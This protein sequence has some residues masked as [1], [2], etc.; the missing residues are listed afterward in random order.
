MGFSEGPA[1]SD[2]KYANEQWSGFGIN[3]AVQSTFR[4]VQAVQGILGAAV[5]TMSLFTAR[6]TPGRDAVPE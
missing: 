4:L 5:L 2:K 1:A 6:V 3:E